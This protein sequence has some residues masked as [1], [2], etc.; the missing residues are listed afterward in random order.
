MSFIVCG[1]ICISQG[2]KFCRYPIRF[3]TIFVVRFGGYKAFKLFCL[4][5]CNQATKLFFLNAAFRF[6]VLSFVVPQRCI[7]HIINWTLYLEFDGTHILCTIVLKLIHIFFSGW[8]C[9][10][11][12][13]YKIKVFVHCLHISVFYVHL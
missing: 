6:F 5:R 4:S 10:S 7:R 2:L 9:E 12:G 8:I 11:W 3:V 1:I 13:R